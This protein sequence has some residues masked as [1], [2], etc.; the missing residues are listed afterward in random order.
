M[1]DKLLSPHKI[2]AVQIVSHA[3][4][5]NA[6]NFTSPPARLCIFFI[7]FQLNADIR[8]LRL[9]ETLRLNLTIDN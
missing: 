7:H 2:P 3:L 8:S 6:L 5:C 1:C 4:H 9:P